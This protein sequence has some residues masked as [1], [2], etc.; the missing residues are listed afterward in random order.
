MIAGLGG[1]VPNSSLAALER[2]YLVLSIL[3]CIHATV[4]AHTVLGIGEEALRSAVIVGL[5]FR[6]RGGC[7]GFK[8]CRL[9]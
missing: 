2:I 4:V 8:S 9:S 5:W 7:Y 1:C 6:L 3:G